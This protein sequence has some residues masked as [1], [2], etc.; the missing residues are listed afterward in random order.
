MNTADE[1]P[2]DKQ[3]AL[4]LAL[5]RLGRRVISANDRDFRAR[6]KQADDAMSRRSKQRHQFM[7]LSGGIV[8]VAV[9]MLLQHPDLLSLR[10]IRSGSFLLLL[11][12]VVGA[13][14]ELLEIDQQS[15]FFSAMSRNAAFDKGLFYAEDAELIV[16][17]HGEDPSTYLQ[18]VA[19]A[20]QHSKTADDQFNVVAHR[21]ARMIMIAHV[22]FFG[23]FV[24]GLLFLLSAVVER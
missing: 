16:R 17:Q 8:G 11:N 12:V 13:I 14:A 1:Q 4:K 9:P 21:F 20:K 10:A 2:S 5:H 22:A 7:L 6:L 18:A 19:E 23:T 15:P 3:L 24:G